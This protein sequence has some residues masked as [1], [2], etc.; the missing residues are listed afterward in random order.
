[1]ALEN[2]FYITTVNNQQSDGETSVIREEAYGS[3]SFWRDTCFIMYKTTEDDEKTSTVIKVYDDNTVRIMRNGAVSSQMVYKEGKKT[4][5]VYKLPYGNIDM[6]I[7]THEVRIRIG[8]DGGKIVLKYT[9]EAQGISLYN[10]M[11]IN[12]RKVK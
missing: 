2:N 7:D 3:V 1:M 10:H 5:F 8:E 6:N 12:V 4:S 11:I 9:L